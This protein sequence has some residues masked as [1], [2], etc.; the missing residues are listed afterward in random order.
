MNDPT[1]R[2]E[3]L[4]AVIRDMSA[5]LKAEAP[6][7]ALLDR[8]LMAS[9]RLWRWWDLGWRALRRLAPALAVDRRP[10]E[11]PLVAVDLLPLT[12]GGANGG[13]KVFSLVLLENMA[14]LAPDWTFVLVVNPG[15]PAVLEELASLERANVRVMAANKAWHAKP[16]AKLLGRPIDLWFCPFTRPNF[17]RQGIPLVSVVHDL[18]YRFYPSFFTE[19][20]LRGRDQTFKLAAGKADRLVCVSEHVRRTVLEYA[21]LPP[22]RVRAIH[23]RL[24]ERLAGP[25]RDAAQA[26]L[27]RLGLAHE[28][29]LL[30]PANFWAHK[31][32]AALLTA[33]GILRAARPGSALKLV[34]TGADTGRA[35]EL[36]QAART[37]GLGEAV[38]FTGFVSD[39][40]LACLTACCKAL[41]FP[42]LFEGFGIPVA[43]AMALGRPVLCSDLTSLPEVGGEAVV[44]FDPRKPEDIARAVARLEDEPDLA[45]RLSALGR[46][47]AAELGGPQD[48]AREY[49][50]V[51]D[52]AMRGLHGQRAVAL[53]L[54]NGRVGP[55][56]FVA[57]GP[58]AQRQWIE[59]EFRL[60]PG[61]RP[62]ALEASVNAKPVRRQTLAPGGSFVFKTLAPPYG[63]CFEV[64][65]Q[66]DGPVAGLTCPRL[67]L[68]GARRTVDLTG[69]L[70]C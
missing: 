20:D 31:N 57:F 38:L 29:Y 40:D 1:P 59:A 10:G 48:M 55:L 56:V 43:E 66:A 25:P 8:A 58:T 7:P 5:G 61:A 17:Q 18:Q 30:Y 33:F 11:N 41:I 50:E 34:L 45:G 62:V 65:F 14:A 51:M 32:H 68:T 16:P 37:M 28:G 9:A 26:V 2:E 6:L 21:N 24:H 36:R 19:P 53:G 49:L 67:A 22:D 60:A 42:S 52:E 23:H 13:A 69:S 63:G 3:A 64:R 4:E 44:Y 35:E 46:A 12:A 39:G 47:R 54:E 27:E 70:S 15:S